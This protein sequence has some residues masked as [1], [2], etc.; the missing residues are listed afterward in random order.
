MNDEFYKENVIDNKHEFR[1]F[2][3]SKKK[4][5]IENLTLD[6]K[7]ENKEDFGNK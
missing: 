5:F 4:K 2:R 1:L 6:S 7:E 3:K